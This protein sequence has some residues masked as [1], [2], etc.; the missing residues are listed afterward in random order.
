[1]KENTHIILVLIRSPRI[2]FV[3]GKTVTVISLILR[4]FGLSTEP[5][6]QPKTSDHNGD[7][8]DD[9]KIF[10]TYWYSDFLTRHVRTPAILKLITRLLK[11][12]RESGYFL[13]PI[14]KFLDV[15]PDY[16]EVIDN[17]I[18]LQV[19][20]I[21]VSET[22]KTGTQGFSFSPVQLITFFCFAFPQPFVGY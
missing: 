22:P 7:E 5:K 4:G 11:T 10:Y 13:P 20:A 6:N 21:C 18:S 9:D 1:M 15:C 14:N 16:F 8:L 17:P 19:S 12:D 2:L 3:V